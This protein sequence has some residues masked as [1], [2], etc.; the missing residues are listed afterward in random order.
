MRSS[1]RSCQARRA[2]GRAGRAGGGHERRQCAATRRTDRRAGA[3]PPRLRTDAVSALSADVRRRPRSRRASA[4]RSAPATC[5]HRRRPADASPKRSPWARPISSAARDVGDEHP[6]AH[7]LVERRARP[8]RAPPRCCRAPARVCAPASPSP[9]T[10]PSSSIAVVPAT[11]TR[12]PGAHDAA[13]SRT[14]PPRRRPSRSARSRPRHAQWRKWRRLVKTI[15][16]PAA[17]AASTTSASR[18]EP[19]GWMIAVD[20]RLDRDLGAVGEREERVGGQH[21]ARPATPAATC[22]RPGARSRRGSSGRRRCPTVA[23]SV[24]EHDRVG[25]HVLADAPGEQQVAPLLVGRLALR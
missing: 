25:A 19:P 1:A 4:G 12:S 9:R 21:G 5:D 14:R 24:R 18:R 16:M 8:A 10:T 13:S 3:S 20:A 17:S 2:V 6:R 11:S 7:D 23:S 22:R 15:A